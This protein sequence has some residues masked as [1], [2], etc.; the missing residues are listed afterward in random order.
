VTIEIN[1]RFFYL[2]FILSIQITQKKFVLNPQHATSLAFV[3]ALY[4]GGQD[5]IRTHGGVS[6]SLP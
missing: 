1:K 3:D 6:P 5:G 2:I 4:H